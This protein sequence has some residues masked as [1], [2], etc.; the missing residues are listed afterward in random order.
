[1]QEKR[2][3]QGTSI[4]WSIQSNSL[5]TLEAANAAFDNFL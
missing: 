5:P 2:D 4:D 3:E 1:M